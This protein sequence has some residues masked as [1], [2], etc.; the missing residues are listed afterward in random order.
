MDKIHSNRMVKI[1]IVTNDADATAQ[2]ITTLFDTEPCHQDEATVP[3]IPLT[4]HYCKYKGELV[5]QARLKVRIVRL[6]PL[7]FEILQP[8]SEGDNPWCDQ[9][10]RNGTSVC[11]ISFYIDRF[12]EHIDLMRRHGLALL[13]E[14]EKGF[15]RYAYFDTMEK[16]GFLLEM[17][18]RVT[19]P[20]G[21]N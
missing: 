5:E 6:L 2:T 19:R 11:F 13:Y 17:K 8:L 21:A 12:E 4:Q 1:G 16:L 18:E 14:E 20:S 9:L 7:Y 3:W 15:E 10:K